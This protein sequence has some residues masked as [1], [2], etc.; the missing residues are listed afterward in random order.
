MDP[1]LK[2]RRG[3]DIHTFA[4]SQCPHCVDVLRFKILNGRLYVKG[5]RH[6]KAQELW[7]SDVGEKASVKG[8][9]V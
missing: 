5:D 1:I 8:V 2:I 6:P 3:A 9:T 4:C 7:H